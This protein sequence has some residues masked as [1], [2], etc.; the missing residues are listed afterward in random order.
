MNKFARASVVISLGLGSLGAVL[1]QDEK[2]ALTRAEVIAERDA[3]R[4]SGWTLA[5]AGEDSGSHYLSQQ[6]QVSTRARAEAV[7]QYGA[8]LAD[9]WS[10][11]MVGEDSGSHYLSQ[12]RWVSTRTRAEV[13][14][15]LEA[16]SRSGELAAMSS[17]DSGSAY[18]SRKI[19]PRAI[20]HAGPGTGSERTAAGPR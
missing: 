17:E 16:A 18:L 3:A 2:G 9:G 10:V 7:T 6:R 5:M 12:Q 20:L 4:A 11:A 1:A 8:R 13:R 14:A 19:T 15:D